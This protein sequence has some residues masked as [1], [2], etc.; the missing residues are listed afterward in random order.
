MRD[1]QKILDDL[2]AQDNLRALK[3]P[4][5][6]GFVNL[7]SNDYLGLSSDA[8]LQKA[9][10]ECVLARGEFMMSNP[11]SRLVTGNSEEYEALESLLAVMYS[12]KSALVVGSGYLTNVGVLPA[13]TE[14]GD[15]VL[16]D[17]L[18]HAS[19]IDGLRL[20][21]CDF[22]RFRHNDLEHLESLLRKAKGHVWVVTESI[23]SMDGDRAPLLELI[24]LKKRYD[25]SIYLDEAHAFGVAGGGAGCAAELGISGDIDVLV[26]TFG[27]ALASTGAFV[28]VS[29]LVREVLV[30]K[31]RTLIFS[32]ALPPISLEWSRM[33]IELLPSLEPRR[34]HLRRLTE[35][36]GGQSHIIPIM[37][38]SNSRAL[39]MAQKMRGEGFWVTPIRYPTVPKDQARIRVSLTAALT[40]GNIR[41]LHNLWK[42]IG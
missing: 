32:T 9:F 31:M 13:L 33:M 4:P 7:S 37:V 12:G 1:W 28:A 22:R 38:G 6:Q 26:G 14:K 21:E 27:K 2:A 19:I 8:E 20:C 34:A 18:V 30:N 11:S 41:R 40:E 39:D 5:T 24:E 17:K 15:L 42:H 35:I 3:M 25:F 16:A 10:F 29:P 36:L 23:F